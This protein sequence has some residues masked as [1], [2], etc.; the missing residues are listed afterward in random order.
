M[1]H[2][3]PLITSDLIGLIAT[4]IAA[5]L[6]AIFNFCAMLIYESQFPEGFPM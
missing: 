1:T 2:I 4:G 6:I 5:A 3:T